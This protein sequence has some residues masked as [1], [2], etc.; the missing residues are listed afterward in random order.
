MY[1][2]IKQQRDDGARHKT[3]RSIGDGHDKSAPTFVL[4]LVVYKRFIRPIEETR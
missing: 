1:E 3:G 2:F 4:M